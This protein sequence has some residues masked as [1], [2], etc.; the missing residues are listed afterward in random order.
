MGLDWRELIPS[1]IL[2]RNG[3]AVTCRPATKLAGGAIIN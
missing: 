1:V 3:L 2:R